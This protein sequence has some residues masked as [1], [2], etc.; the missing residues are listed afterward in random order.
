[1]SRIRS[2]C[3]RFKVS[4]KEEIKSFI[5]TNLFVKYT[6]SGLQKMLIRIGISHQKIH[7]LPGKAET[8]K[9]AVFA[10]KYYQQIDQLLE[11]EAVMFIDAV[12]PQH[13]STPSK[14]WSPIGSPR[15]IQ[16]NTRRERLNI[17]GANPLTQE[18]IVR[19]DTTINGTSTIKLFEQISKYYRLTKS[20]IIVFSDN[21]RS[22]KC[23][24]VKD[25]LA[26][27]SLIKLI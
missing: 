12:H 1:M 13:N 7:R 18:V 3:M 23:T 15:W 22:N 25:W 24:L 26:R 8:V 4:T 2:Y 20:K 21:G 11:N 14:I 10:S 5:G 16:S 9:Q 17:N 27:Q 6:L 19:Q